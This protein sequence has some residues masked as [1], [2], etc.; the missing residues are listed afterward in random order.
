VLESPKNTGTKFDMQTIS[1]LNDETPDFSTGSNCPLDM[2]NSEIS[3][4]SS[5]Y[6]R[7]GGFVIEEL[8]VFVV[9]ASVACTGDSMTIGARTRT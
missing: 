4:M 2:D 9:E 8:L 7:F 5:E 6:L 3:S 1:G